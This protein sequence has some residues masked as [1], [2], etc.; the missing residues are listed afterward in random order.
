[1]MVR[2]AVEDGPLDIGTVKGNKEQLDAFAT[3]EL[4]FRP[5]V[6]AQSEAGQSSDDIN[7]RKRILFSGYIRMLV[8]I[9][10]RKKK[11]M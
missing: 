7:E 11:N 5:W 3:T 9:M 6:S 10:M 1:M 8:R 2:P 4:D